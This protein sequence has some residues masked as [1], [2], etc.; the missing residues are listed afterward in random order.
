MPLLSL[1]GRVVI[2]YAE[3][4][5]FECALGQ[6]F[7]SVLTSTT[8]TITTANIVGVMIASR[9]NWASVAN[10]VERILRLKNRDL[11]AVELV[12]TSQ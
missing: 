3:H 11:E 4:T 1:Q 8:G 9:D 10:Y 12:G 7:R 6:S 5:V 2:D